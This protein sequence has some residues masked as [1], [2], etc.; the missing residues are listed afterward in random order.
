MGAQWHD[1]F[2]IMARRDSH[3]LRLFTR[4]GYNFAGRFP[5]IVAAIASLPV[6][7]APAAREAH[8]AAART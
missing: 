3:G 4:N 7:L 2:R 6:R 5:T 1:G 8:H